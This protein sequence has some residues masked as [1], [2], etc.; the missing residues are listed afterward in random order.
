MGFMVFL[1]NFY[2]SL[3]YESIIKDIEFKGSKFKMDP[4]K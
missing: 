1:Y 4:F 2:I 3:T